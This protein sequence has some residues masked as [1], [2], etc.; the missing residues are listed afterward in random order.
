MSLGLDVFRCL[1]DAG[2]ALEALRETVSPGSG[3]WTALTELIQAID[4]CV[5]ALVFSPALE[6]DVDDA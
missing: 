2:T 4:G 6:R 5:D 1:C 3:A